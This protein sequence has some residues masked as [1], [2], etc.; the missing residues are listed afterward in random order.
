LIL[1]DYGDE[2]D[3]DGNLGRFVGNFSDFANIGS[4]SRSSFED[5]INQ[6]SYVAIPHP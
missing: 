2:A 3:E 5:K 4:I 6:L 1:S